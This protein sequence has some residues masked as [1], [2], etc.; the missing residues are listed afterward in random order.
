M[1]IIILA[2]GKGERLLPLTQNRPKPLIDIGNGMSILDFQ[3]HNICESGVVDK[4]VLVVGYLA[5]QI[6][7]KIADYTS[8]GVAV[9][10][11]FNPFYGTS[12]NL[13]SLWFARAEMLDDNFMVANGDNI[14]PACVYRE[15]ATSTGDGLFLSVAAKANYDLDD[16]KVSIRNGVVSRV[17]KDIISKD[18]HAESIGL[19][20]VK[21]TWARE[22]FVRYLDEI[23]RQEAFLHKFWL[24]IFNVMYEHSVV[25]HP[26]FLDKLT[27]W[28][29][30][31]FPED[32][33]QVRSIIDTGILT[34]SLKQEDA[35]AA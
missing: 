21:G 9:S 14:F 15:L 2:A 4:I 18:A 25:V 11:I 10:T 13:A 8:K 22:A 35:L 5:H 32:L 19:A 12:N 3:I 7:A 29:E 20:L 27:K 31:D 34:T 23:I 17:S 1:K 6:E 28:A 33:Q 24:E 26:W 16:M 30:I